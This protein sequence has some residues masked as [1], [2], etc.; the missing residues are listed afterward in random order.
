MPQTVRAY[1]LSDLNQMTE[2]WNEVVRAG[3][4]FPQENPLTRPDPS[5]CGAD[6]AFRRA[7]R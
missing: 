5:V 6:S 7:C 1:T 4:A 3:N 2:I